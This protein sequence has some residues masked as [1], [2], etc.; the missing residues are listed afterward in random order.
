MSVDV[1]LTITM[2]FREQQAEATIVINGEAAA[3]APLEAVRIM[4]AE[5]GIRLETR[6]DAKAAPVIATQPA[7]P[8]DAPE[9]LG[10]AELDRE[11]A[12]IGGT[13]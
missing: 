9:E 3:I 2:D 4:M 7:P 5:F 12:S 10:D 8:P 13:L 1:Q 11:L 6:E